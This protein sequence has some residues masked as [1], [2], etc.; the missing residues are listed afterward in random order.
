MPMQH[1]AAADVGYFHQRPNMEWQAEFG[2]RYWFSKGRTAKDLYTTGEALISRLTYDGLSNHSGEAFWRITHS[3]GWYFKGYVGGGSLSKGS[4]RDE[5][6]P[7]FITP[8]SSTQSNQAGGNLLYGSFDVGFNVVRGG[9]FRIGTFLGYHYFRENVNAYG[10]TQT[11][12]NPA[13]CVPTIPTSV[14]G[15]SQN[16]KWHMLRVGVDG[17]VTLIDRLTLSVDAA[18]IPVMYFDGA[19]THWLRIGT[20]PGDFIGPI[21]ENGK[22]W[23]Y[24]LE[25]ILSYQITPQASIGVGVRYWRME[26]D[27]HSDFENRVVGLATAAQP[28]DWMAN[29]YGIFIQGSVKFGPYRATN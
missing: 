20:L 25:A 8:Y 26:S 19:D 16:N 29:Q 22:G 5:D 23:G 27:G 14:L 12:A 24:Q 2:A 7:P 6:F 28:V 21:P 18:I 4:L 17:A 1:A 9:D 3:G 10:C 11:A 15:I 13:I